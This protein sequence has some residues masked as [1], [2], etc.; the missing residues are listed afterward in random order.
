[1]TP[2]ASRA[3]PADSRRLDRRDRLTLLIVSA[4]GCAV[5]VWFALSTRVSL[6]DGYITFRYALNIVRGNGF[7]YNVGERVLGTTTPLQTVL[8]AGLVSSFIVGF[9]SLLLL[10][11]LI[12]RGKIY[13]FSYYLIPVGILT[14]LLL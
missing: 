11:R 13:L 7:V 9:F 12:N 1:M 4:A 8:L 6:E 5:W 3:C 14:F 10:L 2:T